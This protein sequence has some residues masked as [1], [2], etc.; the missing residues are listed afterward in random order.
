M[1]FV[2]CLGGRVR[3][4]AP[5]GIFSNFELLIHAIEF[6]L[7]WSL[8]KYLVLFRRNYPFSSSLHLFFAPLDGI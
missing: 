8:V 5:V 4:C 2:L 1:V 6:D 3:S 7:A